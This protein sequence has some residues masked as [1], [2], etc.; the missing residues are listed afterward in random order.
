MDWAGDARSPLMSV[1]CTGQDRES[2]VGAFCVDLARNER[3][4]VLMMGWLYGRNNCYY[5]WLGH[6]GLVGVKILKI[7]VHHKLHM[8]C[9]RKQLGSRVRRDSSTI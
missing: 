3:N 4:R 9:S 8:L 1:R 7:S 5:V 2:T 6:L